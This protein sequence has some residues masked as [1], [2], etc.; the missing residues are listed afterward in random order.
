[1]FCREIIQCKLLLMNLMHRTTAIGN[2]T[3]LI[4]IKFFPINGLSFTIVF[5]VLIIINHPS[6]PSSNFHFGQ[7][8]PFLSLFCEIYLT[9]YIFLF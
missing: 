7:I 1:M 9:N 4:S 2:S 8:Y 5:C 3:Y 6:K